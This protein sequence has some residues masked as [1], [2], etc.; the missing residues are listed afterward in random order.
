MNAVNWV[1]YLAVSLLLCEGFF[2][3]VFPDLYR[4]LIAESE[5]R[6]LQW[7]GLVQTAVVG[8]MLAV[9]LLS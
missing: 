3:S 6:A 2:V 7:A 5:P 1:T 8:G 4:R 9:L